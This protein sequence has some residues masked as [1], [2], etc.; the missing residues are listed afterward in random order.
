FPD[1]GVTHVPDRTNMDIVVIARDSSITL[2]LT[3]RVEDARL[4][5]HPSVLG[6]PDDTLWETPDHRFRH[7]PSMMTTEHHLLIR[8]SRYSIISEGVPLSAIR[9]LLSDD[10]IVNRLFQNG[11]VTGRKLDDK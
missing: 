11:F 6:F 7:R 1:S 8:G 3:E 2:Q 9:A 10:E 5:V 4:G